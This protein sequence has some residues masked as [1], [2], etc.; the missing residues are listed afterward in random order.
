MAIQFY[1]QNSSIAVSAGF[2]WSV[3]AG[4][5][6]G[7]IW[8][9]IAICLILLSLAT[10]HYSFP[11]ACY[12]HNKHMPFITESIATEDY[13]PGITKERMHTSNTQN[14]PNLTTRLHSTQETHNGIL[15]HAHKIGKKPELAAS[16]L[17]HRPRRADRE[18][19]DDQ[20]G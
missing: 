3:P 12:T 17:V 15:L 6:E 19:Q 4:C 14:V 16:F 5:W 13:S 11:S 18:P 20:V 7:Q 1:Y 10:S 9:C 8:Y 2:P